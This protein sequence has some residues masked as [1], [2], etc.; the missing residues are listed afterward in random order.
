[1]NNEKLTSEITDPLKYLHRVFRFTQ[2]CTNVKVRHT[3]TKEMD[4]IIK[5]LKTKELTW[6]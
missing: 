3:T 2:P 6:I 5:L 1:M 4:E